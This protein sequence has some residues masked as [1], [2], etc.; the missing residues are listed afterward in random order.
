M[1]WGLCG[2]L[3]AKGAGVRVT[4]LLF[5]F[6]AARKARKAGSAR[7]G[8]GRPDASAEPSTTDGADARRK[9]GR[10][11]AGTGQPGRN[12]TQAQGALRNG[13]SRRPPRPPDEGVLGLA[14]AF[15]MQWRVERSLRRRDTWFR[16]TD[17]EEVESAYEAMS[18]DE[19]EAINGPQQW[20]NW[21]VIPRSLAGRIPDRPVV[22]VDLGCGS[23]GSTAI[24]AFCVP[25]GS[26]LLGFDVSRRLLE[27]A[28]QRQYVHP[29]GQPAA[30]TFRCQPITE[31]LRGADGMPLPDGSVDVAHSAGVVGH[32]LDPSSARRLA[33]EL[34]RVVRPDGVVVLDAG[35]RLDRRA[36]TA[37]LASCGFERVGERRLCPLNKRVHIVFRP[38]RTAG[39]SARRSSSARC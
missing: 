2:T 25:A 14:R 34:R 32:H 15:A 27:I 22:V 17:A 38:V 24:L 21:R 9:R 10:A 36:L 3:L 39:V 4:D 20:A 23:G 31:T 28:G 35:P 26:R 5:E 12:G 8:N 33:G 7:R 19:F 16:S 18:A 6:A 1:P 29:C 11:G 37:I 30:T 13:S